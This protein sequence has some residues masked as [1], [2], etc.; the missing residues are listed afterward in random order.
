M[1]T[2]TS[3]ELWRGPLDLLHD[4]SLTI[5]AGEKVGITGANGVGK[6]SLFALIEGVLTPE[7]GSFQLPPDTVIAH[8]E[9]ETPALDVSAIEYVLD[10]DTR[11][12]ELEQQLNEA[13]RQGHGEREAQL[14]AELEVIDAYRARTRAAILLSGLGFSE[15]EQGR[16]VASF[17]G[18]WRMRLNLAKALM[19]RSDLLLL[20]EP[21]NHLD[22]DAV[23]WLEKWLKDYRSTLLLISHD[24][25][26]LDNVCNRIAHIESKQITLYSGNYSSFEKQYYEQK[27]QQQAAFVKQQ[28]ERTHMQA[29]VDRF[30]AKA[31]KAKQAQ[32]R[33]KA[34]DRMTEITEVQTSTPFQFAFFPVHELSGTLLNIRQASVGYGQGE[35]FKTVLSDLNF[36]LQAGDRLGILGRNGAGKS[37]LIKVLAD[38]LTL[39]SG[40]QE[41]KEKLKVSYFAQHQLEQLDLSASALLH[42]QRLAP[43]AA[44]QSL[45]DFLGGFHFHGDKALEPVSTFSGGQKARLVLAMLVYQKPD[46]LLLDEPTNHLDMAMRQ[47]LAVALQDY[48]G[49]V[50]VV[51]HDRFLLNLVADKLLLI[52][53]GKVQEYSGS[54]DDYR[55]WLLSQKVGDEKT[56]TAPVSVESKK[57]KRQLAAQKRQQ[58]A[59]LRTQVKKLEQQLEKNTRELDEI[60]QHLHADDIYQPE[61]KARLLELLKQQGQLQQSIAEIEEAWLVATEEMEA[62][63]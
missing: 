40:Q 29:F 54:L 59:P 3:V 23:I 20:D 6:S 28:R 37:T 12:R 1:L 57:Q 35:Q 32:S 56:G 42:M 16:L 24:R 44:E 52:D 30:R 25:D 50:C 61:N 9:Q 2:L 62:M 5:H 14:H 26:F 18:G 58:L 60:N 17:S 27:A 19:C 53:N 41:R 49:A 48:N 33:L 51:S 63:S 15:A 39:H 38:E 31:S 47:A 11:L 43:S 36:N 34:L 7:A 55:Q 22:L 45:R 13:Q 46:V 8:V 4:V 10:G 21:T